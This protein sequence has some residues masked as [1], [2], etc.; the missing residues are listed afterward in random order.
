ML[1]YFAFY[2][3]GKNS[4]ILGEHKGFVQGV[5]WDP[6]GQYVATMSSDRSV[7]DIK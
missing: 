4:G 1:T 2:T 3:A 6:C 5:A 7:L